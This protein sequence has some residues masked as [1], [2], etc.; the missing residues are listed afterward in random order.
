TAVTA[1]PQLD[2][3]LAQIDERLKA[4]AGDPTGLTERGE[5]RLDKGDFTGA[6]AALRTALE[7]HAPPAVLP[8]TRAK[9]FETLTELFQR[10]FDANEKFLEEYKELCKIDIPADADQE[11]RGKLE[12]EQQRR[13]AN[14]LCLLAKGREKQGRL[15]EAFD[16]Y[17]SFGVLNGNK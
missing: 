11:K 15:M 4:N 13:Q 10:D 8:K 5:M 14:F 7:H 12:E 17:T 6:V 1:Y 2:V 16:A 3:K 9:L